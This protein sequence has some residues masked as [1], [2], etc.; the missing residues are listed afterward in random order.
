MKSDT[1]FEEEFTLLEKTILALL[2]LKEKSPIFGKLRL[3]KMI[4]LI[5]QDF[6]KL[7]DELDFEPHRY[8]MYDQTIDDMIGGL[9]L[10]GFVTIDENNNKIALTQKGIEKAGEILKEF[11]EKEI[12]TIEE[13]KELFEDLTEDEILALLYF[14]FP[15]FAKYSEKLNEITKR[16]RELA[17]SLY[18]KGKVSLEAASEIASMNVKDFMKLLKER[19]LL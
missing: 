8:G 17:I 13:V 9:E 19:N 15:E 18:K 14:K 4:F 3:Q 11:S 1:I 12:E 7:R 10:D 6:E 2:Y 5:S 16:R